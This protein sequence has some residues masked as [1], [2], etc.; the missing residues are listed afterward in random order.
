MVLQYYCVAK[1][2]ITNTK[3][4][5]SLLKYHYRDINI[6]EI[7][8]HAL[9]KTFM[10]RVENICSKTCCSTAVDLHCRSIRP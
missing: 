2:M 5:F 7:V 6:I 8:K 9:Q 3:E 4:N 10:S 1:A